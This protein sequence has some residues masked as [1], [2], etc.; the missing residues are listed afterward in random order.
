MDSLLGTALSS[1]ACPL[2]VTHMFVSIIVWKASVED[3]GR[4]LIQREHFV[5]NLSSLLYCN[6]EWRSV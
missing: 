4:G 2:R 3:A 6:G 5:S 1:R